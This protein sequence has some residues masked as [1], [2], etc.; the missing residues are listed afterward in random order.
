MLLIVLLVSFV[1]EGVKGI[2]VPWMSGLVIRSF[3]ACVDRV[4]FAAAFVSG[5]TWNGGDL[6][7]E[8]GFA[9]LTGGTGQTKRSGFVSDNTLSYVFVCGI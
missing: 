2:L 6:N 4:L 8:F 1:F 9:S 3:C 7:Y 5:E